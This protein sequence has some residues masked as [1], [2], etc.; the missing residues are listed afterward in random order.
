MANPD[1]LDRARLHS[2]DTT[3]S[4]LSRT[5]SVPL[6]KVIKFADEAGGYNG[7]IQKCQNNK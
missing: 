2:E 6:N 7:E 3:N 5:W 1:V 4:R